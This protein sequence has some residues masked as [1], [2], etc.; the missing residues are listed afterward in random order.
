MS[1]LTSDQWR[2]ILVAARV[3]DAAISANVAFADP[4]TASTYASIE[5]TIVEAFGEL[6]REGK[7][8]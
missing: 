3:G 8:R 2:H 6:V 5:S 7:I 4:G 1:L